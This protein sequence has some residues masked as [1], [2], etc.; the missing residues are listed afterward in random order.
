MGEEIERGDDIIKANFIIIII[1]S[2]RSQ[3]N[4]CIVLFFLF[5]RE[6]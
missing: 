5:L 1:L 4:L 2:T 6:R 3:A